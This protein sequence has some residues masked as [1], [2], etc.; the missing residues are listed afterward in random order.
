MRELHRVQKLGHNHGSYH[1]ERIDIRAVLREIEAA[2][3]SHGWTQEIFYA[4]EKFQWPAVFLQQFQRSERAG[5]F[6]AVDAR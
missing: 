3:K 2:A 1:G 4:T 5:G 6:V